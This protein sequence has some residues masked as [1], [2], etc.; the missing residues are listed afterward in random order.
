MPAVVFLT[1]SFLCGFGIAGYIPIEKET[2]NKIWCRIAM[3]FGIGYLFSGW[4]AYIVSYISKVCL[5]LN[6]PKTYGNIAAIIISFVIAFIAIRKKEP[7]MMI[8]NSHR[9]VKECLFFGTLF[10]FILWTMF[11]VF[12]MDDNVLSSG[13]TIYSDF[14]P[15]TAM[16]RSF[17]F[18]DNFPTQYPHYGGA[19]VKYHF[20]FQFLTGNLEYLGMR[21]D[22]A[23]NWL[24]ATSLWG[25][26]VL[27]YYFAEQVTGYAATGV[28]TII[29]FF[30]RSSFAGLEKLVQTIASGNWNEFWTNTTFIG[31][32]NHEDWG[33]WNYN[34][35]LNQRHLG[36][37][38]LIASIV[39]IYFASYLDWFDKTQKDKHERLAVKVKLGATKLWK[40]AFASKSAWF[41]DNWK[42]SAML[43]LML[44]ALSFWNGAVVVATLLILFGFAIFSNHKLDCAV[45]ACITL[46]LALIQTNFFM[47]K[48]I[49][50]NISTQYYFGFLSDEL[51][52]HGVIIYI[53][54]L[55][56]IF[57]IGILLFLFIF[58]GKFKAMILTFLVPVFFA[59]TVSM[60]PDIAVNHKYIIIATIF[61]NI[62]WAYALVKLWKWK[63]C[64]VGIVTK[65]IA[66]L[67]LF[68]LVIT[69]AYDLVTIY[70][71]DKD[72]VDINMDSELT[73]WLKCNLTEKDILLSGEDT[74][75]EVTFSG[76]MLYNGWPYY[77]WSAGYDTDTRAQ[78]AIEIYTSKNK[79]RVKELVKKEGITY[80]LYYD[81]LEIEG[82]TCNNDVI[83]SLYDC[84]YDDGYM[85]IYVVD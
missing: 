66:V 61:L 18:H 58:R 12:H 52:L 82:T 85:M 30:C 80:I 72:T 74:M 40:Q 47:D 49:G 44:G 51:T 75:S 14:S 62:F 46:I 71:S 50:Q 15:H 4:I 45:T 24:S 2:Q 57:F 31:Y 73:N 67:I 1:A 55:S 7:E 35:F 13:V 59:F 25:F 26:L 63:N 79:N 17:S 21:I 38:L 6:N 33:L 69:G 10:A 84:E 27:L 64:P 23:F 76:A 5:N 81:G 48:N 28:I 68:V 39:I 42:T 32:T 83:D 78:N 65:A 77:A 11:Y 56:G 29:M 34:V 3:A 43:G 54:C 60:T 8:T 70:N 41:F 36:F 37:G 19:D 53:L 22:C 16:I 20:M 9:A